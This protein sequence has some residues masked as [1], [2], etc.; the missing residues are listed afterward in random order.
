MEC[1]NTPMTR[2]AMNAVTR[3]IA[4]QDQRFLKLSSTGAKTSSSCAGQPRR[5]AT[6]RSLADVVDHRVHRQPADQTL[7]RVDHRRR[8]EVVALEGARRVLG[9]IVRVELHAFRDHDLPHLAL[10]VGDDQARERQRA[11]QHL[12]AVDHELVGVI[13]QL[14]QRRSA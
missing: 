14:V 1:S 11:F 10:Q 13:G 9:A 3:L 4:S 7:G 6:P 5:A 8:D 2:E 12:V